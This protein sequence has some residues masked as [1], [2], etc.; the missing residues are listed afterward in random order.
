MR[1]ALLSKALI[2]AAYRRKC[3]LI[4]VDARVSALAVFVPPA[5]GDAHFESGPTDGYTLTQLPVRF[6]GNFHLHHYP[7]FAAAL[8]R[9]APDIV[10]IDEEPYNIATWL[11]MRDAQHVAPRARRVWFSWQNLL[12][13]YPPPF[14]WTEAA[15]LRGTHAG[16]VGNAESERVWRAKDF[17]GPLTVIPQFG[18]D[19]VAFAPAHKPAGTPGEPRPFTVGFAG[20]LID[21]K[22]V[23]LLLTALRQTP[24]IHARILGDGDARAAL[25]SQAAANELRG[26][27][28]FLP[29]APSSQM[30]DFYHSLD[31]LVL[32]SRTRP[33]WKEQFGR[34][35]IEAM[36]CGVP[37][38]GSDSGEIP[39]VIGDAG[40][41]VREDDAA[42]LAG[43][44]RQ[45]AVAP[46]LRADFAARGRARVLERY[47]M[48]RIAAAT[49]DVYRQTQ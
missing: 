35:L 15:V 44:L 31:A 42:Q 12:R 14:R 4:A 21:D 17:R 40:L 29:S 39:N 25:E 33:N 24:D 36:A 6:N 49:V 16:I 7:T 30:P 23:D 20:R 2:S 22:G 37:V 1:V 11:A 26:R 18:V 27:V 13:T 32:P 38:I 10:H 3:A 34:V 28:T 8:A 48:A 5:W 9:F 46:D 45:L 19:E 47:T 41:I 43:A